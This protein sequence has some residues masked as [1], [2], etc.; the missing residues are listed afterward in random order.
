MQDTL[1]HLNVFLVERGPKLNTVF[2]A[3]RMCFFNLHECALSHII[4]EWSKWEGTSGGHLV[5]PPLLKQ[6]H[7]ET[8]AQDPS[9]TAFEYLQGRRLHKLPGQ[10]VPVLDHPHSKKGFLMFTGKLL[11]CVAYFTYTVQED[12]IRQL[13]HLYT[14]KQLNFKIRTYRIVC[15][16][17]HRKP[18]ATHLSHELPY[19]CQEAYIDSKIECTL[20]KFADDTKLSSAV[21]TPAGWDVI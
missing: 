10:P 18:Q 9:Q 21:D 1:Q 17:L 19:C 20:S 5:Q 11:S 12:H 6:S 14:Y 8:V 16:Q 2:K 3:T 15:D 13:E 4:T 7:L